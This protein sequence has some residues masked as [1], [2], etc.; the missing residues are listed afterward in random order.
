MLRN[1]DLSVY[2]LNGEIID[3]DDFVVKKRFWR[4]GEDI[5]KAN[6]G[7]A[8]LELKKTK[9]ENKRKKDAFR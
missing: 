5:I 8:A 6:Y 3:R 2:F 1:V 4:F 9:D 7:G